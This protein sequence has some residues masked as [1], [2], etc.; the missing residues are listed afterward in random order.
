[1]MEKLN[2]I[3]FYQFKDYGTISKSNRNL[4]A[5]IPIVISYIWVEVIHRNQV[6]SLGIK[7]DGLLTRYIEPLLY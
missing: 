7:N 6:N 1:M 4:V 2:I 3:F 5:F